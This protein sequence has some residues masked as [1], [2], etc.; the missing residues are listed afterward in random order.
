MMG[1]AM[2]APSGLLCDLLR[3]P[4][5][6]ELPDAA[7]EFSWVVPAA[8]SGG[9]QGG[10]QIQVAETPAALK[11]GRGLVWDSGWVK[12]ANSVAVAYAGPALAPHRNYYWHVRIRSANGKPGPYST[13]QQFRT[14]ALDGKPATATQPLVETIVPAASRTAT[15][16]GGVLVDFGRA[17]FGYLT[18]ATGE[19][20]T[21]P[22]T[23]RYGETILGGRVDLNPGV[24]IRAGTATLPA[25]GYTSVRV[26]FNDYER[27]ANA[28]PV[29]GNHGVI[30][31][32][33]YAEVDAA[34]EWFDAARLTMHA[35]HYPFDEAESAFTCSDEWLNRVW[36]LCK[37]SIKATTYAGVYVDGDR[38]R[39]PYEADAYI[40]Q[41]GHYYTDREFA[42]PRH[43]HEYLLDHPTWPTEW[44]FHSIF[45]AWADYQHTGSRKSLVRNYE[46]LRSKLFLDRVDPQTG[47]FRSFPDLAPERGN[48]DLVDWPP[49]ERADFVFEDYNAVLHAFLYRS[50]RLMEQIAMVVDRP[51]DTR[52]YA[53]L[54][55]VVYARVEQSFFDPAQ[56]LYCDGLKTRHASFHA[57]LF[58]LAFGLVPPARQ[59]RIVAFLKSQGMVPSV[60]AAQHFL[61]ALFESGESAAAIGLIVAETDRSWRHMVAAG[62][63]ITWEAWDKRYK[64][65]LDLNHAW[66]AAPANL[67]PAYVLGVRPREPGFARI[68]VDPQLGDLAF[69]EGRVPTI[70][71]SVQV[72]LAREASQIRIKLETPGNTRT[73]FVYRVAAEQVKHVTVNGVTQALR[74]AADRLELPDLAPGR[75]EIVI[76]LR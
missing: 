23:V 7:P 45:M 51:D 37:H 28:V 2:E 5:Q 15:P 24:C 36:D 17:H 69:A 12:G 65:D 29:P 25:Q 57:N 4:E 60:Y 18:I 48:S 64:H 50:L 31:P 35:L 20:L 74:G 9:R 49:E 72:K 52:R 34:A 13:V 73:D 40:N 75:T 26:P 59:E 68:L 66:G 55:E 46:R 54:A 27:P 21:S 6:T 42:L 76:S 41:L 70:R 62:A 14:R 39:I 53:Q 58:A 33:R 61:S 30:L 3:W 16:E 1:R 44:K 67:I 47:L 22:L 11:A 71:G 63:T 32:F 10:Y 19:P 38:E 56:G 8:L 43:S